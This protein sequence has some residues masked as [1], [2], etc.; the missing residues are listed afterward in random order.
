M[1]GNNKRSNPP[2]V[3]PP[4]PRIRGRVVYSI[5]RVPPSKTLHYAVYCSDGKWRVYCIAREL[6]PEYTNG[7][8]LNADR[9]DCRQCLFD[10]HWEGNTS[11]TFIY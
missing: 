1:R 7:V 11:K 3:V 2:P 6:E 10:I 8:P 9:P 4:T 5:V